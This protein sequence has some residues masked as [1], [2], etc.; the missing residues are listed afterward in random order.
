MSIYERQNERKKKERD[1][2]PFKERCVSIGMRNHST[3]GRSDFYEMYTKRF[4]QEFEDVK[5][6]V[7]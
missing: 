5:V 1:P 2:N 3:H 7:R 4:M 6:V